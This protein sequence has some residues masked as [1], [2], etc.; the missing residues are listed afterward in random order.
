MTHFG[1]NARP[2]EFCWFDL[3]TSDAAAAEGF[4]GQL[5]GWAALPQ[6]V[7][8]GSFT[9]LQVEG[10]DIASLYPL[11]LAQVKA[12]VPSHWTPYVRVAEVDAA[13]LRAISLGAAQVIQPFLISGIARI[14]LLADPTGALFGLFEP[15]NGAEEEKR[16]GPNR[17]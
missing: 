4:Y 5:F 10:R 8:G 9:R 16:H 14:A 12:G 2:G 11:P 15:V 17:W 3:A 1:G 6:V 13:V 7:H